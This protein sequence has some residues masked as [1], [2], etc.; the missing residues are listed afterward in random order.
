MK[1]KFTQIVNIKKRNLDKIELNLAKKRNE[2]AII[3]GFVAQAANDITAYEIPSGGNFNEMRAS[4]EILK[5]MRREKELLLER[6]S[7]TKKE[8]VHLEH[9]YKN[10]NL[11]FEKMKYL[12]TQDFNVQMENIK[13]AETAAMDEFATMKFARLKKG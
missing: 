8:I 5:A 7:L 13:K 2:A 11:E 12:Q 9:R 10:A 1:S 6:L 4:L 3:E